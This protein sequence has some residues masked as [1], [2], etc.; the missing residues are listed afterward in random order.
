MSVSNVWVAGSTRSGAP[1]EDIVQTHSIV[2]RILVF[3]R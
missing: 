3:K 1:N 2:E